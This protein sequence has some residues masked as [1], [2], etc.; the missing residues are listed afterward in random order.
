MIDKTEICSKI[1]SHYSDTMFLKVTCAD[2]SGLLTASV[3]KLFQSVR[4]VPQRQVRN[5]MVLDKTYVTS[6]DLIK[7]NLNTENSLK[8]RIFREVIPRKTIFVFVELEFSKQI[9]KCSKK[10]D[11]KAA[12]RF[13]KKERTNLIFV[14]VKFKRKRGIS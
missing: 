14:I 3:S 12:W 13:R 2:Q 6:L 5:T 10:I 11:M 8:K 9:K 4:G 7:V 1:R